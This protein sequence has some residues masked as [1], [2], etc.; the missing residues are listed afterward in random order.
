MRRPGWLVALMGRTAER[1]RRC[2]HAKATRVDLARVTAHA[3]TMPREIPW[4]Y[5]AGEIGATACLALLLA[6][7]MIGG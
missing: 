3:A 2:K 1:R 7:G 4:R 6:L 5:I